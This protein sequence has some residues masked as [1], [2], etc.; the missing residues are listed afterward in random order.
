MKTRSCIA[1][2]AM[3]VLLSLGLSVGSG[4]ADQ[5]NQGLPES[6]SITIGSVEIPIP[7][8]AVTVVAAQ[9]TSEEIYRKVWKNR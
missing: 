1:N 4:I 7:T 5:A 2:I 3:A 6:P 8:T 9:T